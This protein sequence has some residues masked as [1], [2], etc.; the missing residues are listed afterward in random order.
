MLHAHL[1]SFV[2]H[3][4]L[5][6]SVTN[7]THHKPNFCGTKII[8]SNL[9][10]TRAARLGTASFLGVLCLTIYNSKLV[11]QLMFRSQCFNPHS[12]GK[13][14]SCR[15]RHKREVSLVCNRSYLNTQGRCTAD[16]CQLALRHTLGSMFKLMLLGAFRTMCK[17]KA[18]LICSELVKA[19]PFA[20][21][22]FIA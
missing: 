22:Q 8:I 20:V 12:E 7:A 19:I 21:A 9:L 3:H 17:I 5:G 13:S 15:T 4:Y 18:L 16:T 10:C 6:Q 2:S 1:N 14:S 11:V